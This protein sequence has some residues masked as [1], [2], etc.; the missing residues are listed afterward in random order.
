[1]HYHNIKPLLKKFSAMLLIF[2]KSSAATSAN[3]ITGWRAVV[4]ESRVSTKAIAALA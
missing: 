4:E 2:G 1:M 3:R